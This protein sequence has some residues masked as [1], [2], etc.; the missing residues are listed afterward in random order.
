MNFDFN[1]LES[2]EACASKAGS[3][4]LRDGSQT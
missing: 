3:V 1:K 2:L 4:K